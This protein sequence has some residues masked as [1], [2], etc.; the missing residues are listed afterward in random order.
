VAS[1]AAATSSA[2]PGQSAAL[3]IGLQNGKTSTLQQL[4]DAYASALER[5]AVSERKSAAP[6]LG[7]RR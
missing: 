4:Y 2:S 6:P 7:G 1:L 3:T 5:P